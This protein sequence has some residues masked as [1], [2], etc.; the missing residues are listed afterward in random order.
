MFGKKR[1]EKQEAALRKAEREERFANM[2]PEQR[3]RGIAFALHQFTHP[4][5]RRMPQGFTFQTSRRNGEPIADV[6]EK[7]TLE[8]ESL[9][10]AL[11]K[12]FDSVPFNLDSIFDPLFATMQKSAKEMLIEV[13]EYRFYNVLHNLIFKTRAI[14][15]EHK[16]HYFEALLDA[17][18]VFVS[19]ALR[20]KSLENIAA[21]L[22]QLPRQE[23]IT[24]AYRII[25]EINNVSFEGYCFLDGV[26]RDCDE[27]YSPERKESIVIDLKNQIALQIAFVLEGIND[28]E[29]VD[30]IKGVRATLE[31]MLDV[32]IS[33]SVG[34]TLR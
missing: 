28:L 3:A 10:I 22:D 11:Q 31:K 8:N 6:N 13:P 21:Y 24:Q 18:S 29:L 30:Q 27:F 4:G 26:S 2:S 16:L 20:A 15:E 14:P 5:A 33:A 19:G 9:E 12:V 25:S 7:S 1:K 34:F 32:P 17:T 23:I